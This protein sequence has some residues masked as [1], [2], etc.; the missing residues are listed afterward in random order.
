M[1]PSGRNRW[2]PVANGSAPKRLKQADRQPVATYGNGFGV[3]G[4]E[5]VNVSSPLEGF[6]KDL[7]SA[8]FS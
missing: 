1:E 8:A 7:L 5:E 2:Q 6:E 3:H 4:K